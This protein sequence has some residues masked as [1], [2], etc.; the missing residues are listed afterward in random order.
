MSWGHFG[1]RVGTQESHQQGTD[2]RIAGRGS[3]SS[4]LT[5]SPLESLSPPGRRLGRTRACHG[6]CR[7][8]VLW[9]LISQEAILL[10][11]LI[12]V[13]VRFT[14]IRLPNAAV[15]GAWG[16]AASVASTPLTAGAP[17]PSCDNCACPQMARQGP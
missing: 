13:V 5:P 15:L 2:G 11:S 4:H 3:L 6:L 8:L 1:H 17:T 7:W 10:L 12:T 14:P 9:A 16:V